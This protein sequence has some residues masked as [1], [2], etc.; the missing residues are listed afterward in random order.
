MNG[1]PQAVKSN[2]FLYADDSYHV[3]QGKNIIEIEKQLNRD[4][5]NICEWL[6]DNRLSIHSGDDRIK[7]ILFYS[8]RKKRSKTKHQ[9]Q[10]YTKKTTFQGHILRLHIRCSNVRRVDGSKSN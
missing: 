6:L 8:K 10:K 3:F 2:L 9:L 7:S 4:F 5:T 1:K